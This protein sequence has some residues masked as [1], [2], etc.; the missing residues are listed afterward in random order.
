MDMGSSHR[1]IALLSV[2]LAM[3]GCASSASLDPVATPEASAYRLGAGDEVR[4]TVYGL[5]SANNT[6]AVSDTGTIS[7]PLLPPIPVQGRT[8]DE[9]ATAIA[10][11]LRAKQLVNDPSVSAQVVKYRPFFILGEVQRPG[12]YPY[13]PGMSVLT[14][15]SIAGGYTFR[16]DKKNASITRGTVKG[17]ASPAT[18]IQ[19]GDTVQINESWF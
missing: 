7:L 4:V 6:Y 15:V 13:V 8:V 11:E 19:P 9:A 16:A 10:A 1:L 2:G 3:T 5:D 18:A 17:Q 12:Q 14:A